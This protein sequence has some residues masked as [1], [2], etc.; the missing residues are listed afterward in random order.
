MD[1][2]D[3]KHRSLLVQD[4]ATGPAFPAL[5]A[6][7]PSQS[8][9]GRSWVHYSQAPSSATNFVPLDPAGSW[10]QELQTQVLQHKPG[11]WEWAGPDNPAH[12]TRVLGA[13]GGSCQPLGIP[14][15]QAQNPC[16]GRTIYPVGSILL[17]TERGQREVHWR[18]KRSGAWRA[19]T[20]GPL[21]GMVPKARGR[22]S[23]HGAPGRGLC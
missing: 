5:P 14:A 23:A 18:E 13:S 19:H 3:H 9:Q 16:S 2:G 1:S 8:L 15:C 10:V 4:T 17:G 12:G 11:F 20:A 6:S 21:A 22:V 7:H